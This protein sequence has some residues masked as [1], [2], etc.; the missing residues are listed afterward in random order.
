MGNETSIYKVPTVCQA[1]RWT[2]A[3]IGEEEPESKAT[4][5]GVPFLCFWERPPRGSR[6]PA[7][8]RAGA[9]CAQMVVPSALRAAPAAPTPPTP[10]GRRPASGAPH[11]QGPA[12]ILVRGGSL[13]LDA[14]RPRP[15]P[16]Q[17]GQHR[18]LRKE[19]LRSPVSPRT[20]PP[21]ARVAQTKSECT[22]R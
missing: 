19:T 21:G 15:G 10:L 1:L 22:P 16:G 20:R 13:G 5:Q 12:P 17:S 6:A 18:H 4:G 8:R 3:Q 14:R 9:G 11:P 2:L 7:G